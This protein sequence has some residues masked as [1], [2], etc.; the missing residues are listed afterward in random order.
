MPFLLV[1]LA[2]T[3]GCYFDDNQRL[4]DLFVWVKL[5]RLASINFLIDSRYRES[6]KKLIKLFIRYKF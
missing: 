5:A 3:I 2:R 1:K 6:I 4:T